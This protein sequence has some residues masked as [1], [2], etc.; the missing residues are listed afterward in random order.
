MSSSPNSSGK[1]SIY[2]FLDAAMPPTADAST[3]IVI[4]CC[5]AK[6]SG[7]TNVAMHDPLATSLS[8][9]VYAQLCGARRAVLA[10]I[11]SEPDLLTDASTRN[12][13]LVDGPDFGGHANSGHYRPALERY[14]G[15][16]YAVPNGRAKLYAS[17]ADRNAPHVL[18]LSALYGPLHPLSPIQDYN[19]RM[20]QAPARIWRTAFLPMP[21]QYVSTQG[22]RS[23]VLLVGSKTAYYRV[24]SRA[25]SHLLRCG[26][27]TEA[28]QYH[29]LDGNSR[30][31]PVEHGRILLDLLSGRPPGSTRAERRNI[32]G[33][34]GAIP[35]RSPTVTINVPTPVPNAASPRNAPATEASPRMRRAPPPTASAT[36]AARVAA[37]NMLTVTNATS[38]QGPIAQPQVETSPL[39]I[40]QP[41]MTAATPSQTAKIPAPPQVPSVTGRSAHRARFDELICRLMTGV[42][43]GPTTGS[44][45]RDR[46]LTGTR[47]VFFPRSCDI[48]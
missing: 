26:R 41:A 45:A 46:Q 34:Q 24:A 29:I 32:D 48:E 43:Q 42:D 12:R 27:I 28:S 8:D 17:V 18:I 33:M 40:R 20:D 22:I 37:R 23:I 9:T 36:E 14:A 21:D 38:S 4:P 35:Y 44:V 47:R 19:L 6:T 10:G 39:T 25:A 2:N 11:Q 13:A 31:T 1:P 15:N 7:G 3:L 5:A 30:A 16:L